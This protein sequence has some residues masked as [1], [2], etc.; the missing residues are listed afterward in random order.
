M[1]GLGHSGHGRD[2]QHRGLEP[3]HARLCAGAAVTIVDFV[4]E[5]YHQHHKEKTDP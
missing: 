3:R 5:T 4:T 1:R 2:S